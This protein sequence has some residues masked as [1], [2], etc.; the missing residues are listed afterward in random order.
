[1]TNAQQQF[2]VFLAH[3]SLDKPQVRKIANELKRR[4]LKPWL[5][6]EQIPPG[7]PFQYEIQHAIPLVKSVAIFIS[8]QELGKWQSSELPA[9]ISLCV[10]NNIPVIPI[11][12]PG[13]KSIPENLMFLKQFRWIRFEKIDDEKAFDL[14]EWGII[15]QKPAQIPDSTQKPGR[16]PTYNDLSLNFSINDQPTEEDSLGF[17]PYVK[18]IAEFLTNPF[19]EPPLT[20]SI[21]GAWGSGKSSF[22]KQLSKKLEDEPT[23]WFNAWR[24]DKAEAL[25]AAFA[26]EFIRQISRPRRRRDIFRVLKG[27]LKL[28]WLR[29]D[30]KNGFQLISLLLLGLILIVPLVILSLQQGYK[31]IEL[32]TEFL[33]TSSRN[34][35]DQTI[36][37]QTI[38]NWKNILYWVVTLAAIGSSVIGYITF[39]IKLLN[40]SD[41]KND[42]TK[43]LRSPN[44]ENQIPFVEKFHEDFRKIVEAYA[45]KNKVYVFI[46]DLDRCEIPKSAELMQ[47]INL[48]I[49]NDPQLI[50]ILGM[51]REKVAAGF[52]FKYKLLIPYLQ[53]D[54]SDKRSSSV[55]GMDY[56]YAYIEKFIQ[57]PFQL[58]EPTQDRFKEFLPQISPSLSQ[59]PA[60]QQE[61]L[62]KKIQHF[63]NK[64]KQQKAENPASVT[65]ENKIQG[66][67]KRVEEMIATDKREDIAKNFAYEFMF[68]S[69]L[70][71]NLRRYKQF[72]NLFRLKAF[73]AA[74][75]NKLN[76]DDI[77][78]AEDSD[79]NKKH[80]TLQQLGKFTAII[81]KWPRLLIYLREDYQLL[82]K[83]Q[84]YAL[85]PS[86]NSDSTK[87]LWGSNNEKLVKFL[88]Y[89]QG[90]Q[91]LSEKITLDSKYSIE[92]VD[93]TELL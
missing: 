65:E 69:T 8:L 9:L 49:S 30:W 53:H 14:L 55:K 36:I 13:V 88:R 90:Q 23:V 59:R 2:D 78:E 87:K 43:Y 31:W 51:D 39:L 4:G 10:K 57:I 77:T 19:T 29:F 76:F 70:D 86:S 64:P 46:D 35:I 25:W 17:K 80:L 41:P 66:R 16:T 45:G 32:L 92:N 72:I 38:D 68:I 81:I 75:N 37:D 83:L 61:S 21:E 56:A 93:I 6:E 12:L 11:L 5:D 63:L 52:A 47:A 28:F 71:N 74:A 58:P 79:S 15:G 42:L 50:F 67:I 7:R 24:H 84:R 34:K 82:A 40:I 33:K 91:D 1:M 27:N 44:Y 85:D 18:A 73:I 48:M 54:D 89:P 3:N 20:I 62:W 22:M 26:L 60:Q